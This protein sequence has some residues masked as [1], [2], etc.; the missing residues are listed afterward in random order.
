MRSVIENGFELTGP[1]SRGDWKTV[2]RHLEAIRETR[3]DL[4]KLYVALAR[5]TAEIA[6]QEIPRDTVSPGIGSRS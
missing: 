1:I 3:P 2:E 6:G 5:A 4:A